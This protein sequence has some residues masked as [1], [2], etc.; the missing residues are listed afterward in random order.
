MHT[1]PFETVDEKYSSSDVNE[2]LST[3]EKIFSVVTLKNEKNH[4]LYRT[5]ATKKKDVTTKCLCTRSNFRQ[6]L[7]TSVGETKMVE[8]TPV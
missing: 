7:M 8:K 1:E 4:Q 6:S 5:V 3:D 2:M